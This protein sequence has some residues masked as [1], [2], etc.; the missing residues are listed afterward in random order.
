MNTKQPGFLSKKRT[1][2]VMAIVAGVLLL[3]WG[4]WT[5]YGK[6]SGRPPTTAQV[7]RSI[8]KFLAKKSGGRKFK[9]ELDLSAAADLARPTTL[10]VTNKTGSVRTVTRTGRTG[11]RVLPETTFSAYFRTNQQDAG[12]YEH[13]YQLIGEQ[14]FVADKLLE[15]T[16]ASRQVM[17]LVMASEA[18]TYARTNVQSLWLSARIC[19]AY[20]WPNLTLVETTN[21]N[22]LT[23]GTILDLCEASFKEAG[24]TNHLIRIY[25]HLIAQTQGSKTQVDLARFRLSRLYQGQNRDT[26]ALKLLK[27][28]KTLT[29]PKVAQDIA[30]LERKLKAKKP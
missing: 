15:S 21:R 9:P 16:E 10:T 18:S 1:V 30:V 6:F 7:K 29:S 22:L 3:G 17:G 13:M 26:E 14:L 28:I 8:W 24:E 23:P 5:A 2:V 19:E 27:E 4:S 11:G 12:S 20:L 25:E